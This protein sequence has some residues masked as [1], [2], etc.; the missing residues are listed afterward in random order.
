MDLCDCF[1]KPS[2]NELLF[3]TRVWT[4]D[5]YTPFDTLVFNKKG[6]NSFYNYVDKFHLE[7]ELFECWL[8]YDVSGYNYWTL[9]MEESNYLFLT[10]EF[11]READESELES[12]FDKIV[13]EIIYP[14][15]NK[16]E[17]LIDNKYY[18]RKAGVK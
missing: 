1:D 11:K 3:D 6:Y 12:V 5:N 17:S 16:W 15:Q 7:T 10:I 2:E 4:L 14:L 13:N 9:D 18:I 8:S